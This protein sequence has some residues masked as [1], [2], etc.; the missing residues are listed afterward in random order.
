M[1]HLLGSIR[2]AVSVTA[3]ARMTLSS[4]RTG[5]LRAAS[6]GG[7]HG[8][9]SDGPISN[10]KDT[11]ARID[12]LLLELNGSDFVSTSRTNTTLQ[13]IAEVSTIR[14]AGAA[15]QAS[16][17]TNTDYSKFSDYVPSNTANTADDDYEKFN[18]VIV[19][20]SEICN[21]SS[22]NGAR[23]VPST[24]GY[25]YLAASAA[26]VLVDSADVGV[27]A[28]A[29][30]G[31][32]A[33][34]T[35]NGE[36]GG[37]SVPL[38]WSAS[39]CPSPNLAPAVSTCAADDAATSSTTDGCEHVSE[40]SEGVAHAKLLAPVVETSPAGQQIAFRNRAGSETRL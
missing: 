6:G 24:A 40:G 34:S 26:V 35:H 29:G 39:P 17:Q 27:G 36:G 38:I 13:C 8:G 14:G 1:T 23:I 32:G 31:A 15:N 16:G 33:G 28:G 21:T 9:S 10:R 20:T 25:E 4:H 7:G 5:S 11:N 22:A 19:Q 12:R 30:A 18:D 2:G 37:V 3:D